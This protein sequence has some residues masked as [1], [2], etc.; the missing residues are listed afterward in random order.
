[1]A[2]EQRL[3]GAL[4][5]N[6]LT[7]LCFSD[8]YAALIRHAVTPRTFESA[9][10]R[11]VAE[12]AIDFIDRYKEP[13]KEHLADEL[14][15]V[16]RGDDRRKAATYERLL[17]NL[18]ES[19]ASINGEY[20]MT[21]LR[22]FV[23]QQNLKVG[24]LA[25]VEALEDG[26]PDAAE[27][28][29]QRALARQI[30][31]FQPGL[32]FSKPEVVRSLLEDY[33]EPGFDLLIPEFDKRGIIPRRKEL[34]VFMA[35]RGRGK[36]WFC[37][38]A[39]KAAIMQR[40]S[41]LVVTLE[42]SEKRYAVR[43]LQSFFGVS[44]RDAQTRVAR[45][46][47]DRRGNLQD[48]VYEMVD[49]MTL[50]E[51]GAKAELASRMQR[52]FR[53]RKP[54]MIKQFPTNSLKLDE[55][56]AYLDGLARHEGWTPDLLIVDYPDLM[57]HDPKNK[58]I[59]VG[60]IV[61]GIRGLCVERNMA[62]I[63]PTQGNRESEKAKTVTNDMAAEDISKIATADVVLTFSQTRQERRLG[64]ARVLADKVRN[65]EDKV[66]V[67]LT[68]AYGIGQFALESTRMDDRYWDVIEDADDG[69]DRDGDDR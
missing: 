4:Q 43:F 39:A 37:V 23:R 12:H 32:N 64:L 48:V 61:E 30:N 50:R 20:V 13:I 35:P 28:E 18:Y 54:L 44:T 66:M 62:G 14:E 16:V 47:H 46:V 6:V 57:A 56:R 3:S 58:R 17:K 59:E 41:V 51:D 55:L 29:M 68:Q 8:Q 15:D 25:A 21:Q 40:W 65:E 33:E 22:A 31:V 69:D 27:V 26:R 52:E 60:M 53:R 2:D 10:F 11:D 42:M 9:P 1:M 5:E 36:S 19:H 63:V 34:L 67:L 49:T 38:H 24:L 7:L 45:L